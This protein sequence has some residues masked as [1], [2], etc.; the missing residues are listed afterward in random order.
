MAPHHPGVTHG[1]ACSQCQGMADYAAL[2]ARLMSQCQGQ[3]LGMLGPGRGRG[4][5]APEDPTQKN[6][7]QTERSRSALT[8]GKILMQWK[9]KELAPVGETKLEYRDAMSEVKQ[10]ASEAI[11]HEQIPPGY[12]DAIGKYFD[13]LDPET[14]PSTTND[15]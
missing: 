10:G 8:A 11:F 1:Q 7:Y 14:G 13:S 5:I 9:T 2:Y 12:H 6:Q 4:N 3:G 15:K